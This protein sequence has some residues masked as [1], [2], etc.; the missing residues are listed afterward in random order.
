MI[1]DV[2]PLTYYVHCSTLSI[3][4][5]YM[6]LFIVK[7]LVYA[8]FDVEVHVCTY[9]VKGKLYKQLHFIVKKLLKC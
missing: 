4:L 3:C 7:E 8:C 2:C 5:S 6:P 1:P 9:H